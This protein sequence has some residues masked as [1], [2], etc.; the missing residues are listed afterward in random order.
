MTPYR[1][2]RLPSAVARRPRRPLLA[3]LALAV[4]VAVGIGCPG[5]S[6]PID[7]GPVVTPTG[8]TSTARVILGTLAWAVPAARAITDVLVPEPERA[9]VARALGGV[10]AAALEL[11]AAVDTYDLRG[12][13]RCVAH[14][15]VGGL[16]R[17]LI[18]LA[19][20]L[21]DAGL[22]LGNTL[23]RVVDGAGSI[24]DALVPVCEPDAGWANTGD[25][26]NRELR[27]VPGGRILGR[28]LDNLR[29]PT[30][31]Q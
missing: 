19:R 31:A 5:P 28:A 29:P 2:P 8:W 16:H 3:L 17:A 26:L 25:R 13:D 6:T 12:G 30:G 14:A 15:A 4:M 1:S 21:A 7:G 23:E 11:Q 22:A 18:G 24:A 9:I 27:A 10:G 20:V